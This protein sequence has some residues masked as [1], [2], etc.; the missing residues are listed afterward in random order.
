MI[1]CLRSCAVL[2]RDMYLSQ[3]ALFI[4]LH[5][6][7]RRELLQSVFFV[8]KMFFNDVTS[9]QSIFQWEGHL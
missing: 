2:T 8:K 3:L 5:L 1:L 7:E 9:K 6:C 4:L